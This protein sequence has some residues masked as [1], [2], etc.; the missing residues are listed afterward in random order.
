M[1]L[2]EGTLLES[3]LLEGSLLAMTQAMDAPAM[4]QAMDGPWPGYCSSRRR[5]GAPGGR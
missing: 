5:S 4:E 1:A 2:L 3:T